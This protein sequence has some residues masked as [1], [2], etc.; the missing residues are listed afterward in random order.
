MMRARLK[1]SLA[2]PSL[3][4]CPP[5]DTRR[6]GSSARP[7]LL[8]GKAVGLSQ[9]RLDRVECRVARIQHANPKVRSVD[10]VRHQLVESREV[11]QRTGR[12]QRSKPGFATSRSVL[13]TTNTANPL[14]L[15]GISHVHIAR[16]PSGAG[17]VTHESP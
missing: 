14:A 12:E 4:W 16:R 17:S 6:L 9:Q 7:V 10:G 2:L 3:G 13:L 5:E 15:T 8:D 11:V 1:D